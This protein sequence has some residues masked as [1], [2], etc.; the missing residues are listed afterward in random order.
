MLVIEKIKYNIYAV[1]FCNKFIHCSD[2]PKFIFGRNEYAESISKY[3]NIDGYIDEFT[4]DTIYL[5]KPIVKLDRVPKNALVISSL[6]GKPLTA[7]KKLIHSS[8][9]YLDYFS[10][11]KYSQLSVRKVMFWDNFQEDLKINFYKYKNVYNR[12][13]DQESK[14]IFYRIVN[15]RNSYDLDYMRFFSA[16]EDRQYFEPFLN[17]KEKNESFI[18]VG[19]FDGYTSYEFIKHC[20]FY[21]EIIFFEPED[22]NL[23]I[24][25][26]KLKDFPNIVF[27]KS[28][29]SNK[30]QTLKFDISGSSSKISK[31]G[32]I[33]I[34]VEKLDDVINKPVTFIKM[35]IEG[36]EKE[37][38]EGSYNVIKNYHPKLAIAVYHKMEDIW[39]VPELILNIRNDYDIYLRHYTEG[40]AETIMFFIPQEK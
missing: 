32:T 19:G 1:D 11:Y 8:L 22:K 10:F 6:I 17:L 28:G 38:I 24:A 39:A 13:N 34:Q 35:D 5:G 26:E 9:S 4:N 33:E 27:Y 3:V 36:Y 21:N 29:L 18:D 30:K 16:N 37:A 31:N 40:I 15:F 14:D 12:L 25:R 20:P 2:N 23:N 7:E